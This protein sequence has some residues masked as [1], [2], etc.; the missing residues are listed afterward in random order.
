MVEAG[1]GLISKRVL[2]G[3]LRMFFSGVGERD[4]Q[5][6]QVMVVVQHLAQ[7][8]CAGPPA[9]EANDGRP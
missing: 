4:D 2:G 5:I 9:G 7:H 3:R 8:V 1:E 6:V